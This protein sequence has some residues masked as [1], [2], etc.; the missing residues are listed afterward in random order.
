MLEFHNRERNTVTVALKREQLEVPYGIAEVRDGRIIA[1]R[2]KP[3]LALDVNAGVYIA[4]PEI[5]QRVRTGDQ[6]RYAATSQ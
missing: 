2:E 5:C 3:A 1:L 6:A 4:S